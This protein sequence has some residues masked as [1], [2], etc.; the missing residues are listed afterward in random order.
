MFFIKIDKVSKYLGH[1]SVAITLDV[2]VHNKKREWR[3]LSSKIDFLNTITQNFKKIIQSII[4]HF[5]V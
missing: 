1:S 4:T 5:I 2:Y 3:S